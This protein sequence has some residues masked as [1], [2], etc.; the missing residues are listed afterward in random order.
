MTRKTGS[1]ATIASSQVRVIIC[2]YN[3]CSV[4]EFSWESVTQIFYDS[5]T[6][7]EP[8]YYRVWTNIKD[9]CLYQDIFQASGINA[10]ADFVTASVYD[11]NPKILYGQSPKLAFSINSNM[12]G[13][14]G[15]CSYLNS[16]S[17]LVISR[18]VPNPNPTEFFNNPLAITDAF[19][20]STQCNFVYCVA[21]GTGD[22]LKYIAISNDG[23]PNGGLPIEG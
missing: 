13:V 11:Q 7:F 15:I 19:V 18:T 21:P 14:N 12:T 10:L 17:D 3:F 6:D 5:W 2:A 8:S 9:V 4:N 16:A 23:N 22:Q 20:M 1:V